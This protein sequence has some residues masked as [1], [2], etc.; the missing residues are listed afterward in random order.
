MAFHAGW[1]LVPTVFTSRH[2]LELDTLRS[3]DDDSTSLLR[4][5]LIPYV[6]AYNTS[7]AYA[8]QELARGAVFEGEDWLGDMAGREDW[9]VGEVE[10]V[11]SEAV[12]GLG[13]IGE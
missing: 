5:V 11:T 12:D 9:E 13:G 1:P 3:M 8:W 7:L 10:G 6:E 4:S 2:L